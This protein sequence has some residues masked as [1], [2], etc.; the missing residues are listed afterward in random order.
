ME[1]HFVDSSVCGHV[2][3]L[4]PPSAVVSN[5]AV[6]MGVQISLLGILFNLLGVFVVNL[7]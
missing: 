4:L 2:G 3:G 7:C 6:N 1:S 5:A